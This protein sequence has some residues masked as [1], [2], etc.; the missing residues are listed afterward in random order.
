MLLL[1]SNFFHWLSEA[2]GDSVL[3][4]CKSIT[5]RSTALGYGGL[6][7]SF[8]YNSSSVI[9]N[10]VETHSFFNQLILHALDNLLPK[11]SNNC[12]LFQDNLNLHID[13]EGYTLG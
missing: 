2:T 5:G 12:R 6:H 8:Y 7:M 13:S 4:L 1:K 3:K 10:C 9:R 11:V